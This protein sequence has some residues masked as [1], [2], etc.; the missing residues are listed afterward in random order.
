MASKLSP[1]LLRNLGRPS[2]RQTTT[3]RVCRAAYSTE[4]PPP[5]F[6]AKLKEDLKTAMRAKDANRLAVL[7]SVLA[8]TLNR[9]KTDKPIK[10]DA[11]LVLLLKKLASKS[12]EAA[13]EAR[14]AGRE[15]LAEK[16]EAQQQILEEYAANSGVRQVGEA[17]LR[18]M[19]EATKANLVAQGV[20]EKALMGQMIASLLGSEGS[21]SNTMVA[22]KEVIA[23]IKEACKA[24]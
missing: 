9:S 15:D 19:V 7:R 20:K 4:A 3:L 16:E 17:E 24:Y 2:L 18:R 8:E 1:F 12:Q 11:Q 22:Q 5:P 23:L 14:A 6:L 10:N 21:L 13:A